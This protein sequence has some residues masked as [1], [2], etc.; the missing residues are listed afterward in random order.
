MTKGWVPQRTGLPSLNG[1]RKATAVHLE[2]GIL[3]W[4]HG[5]TVKCFC[6]HKMLDDTS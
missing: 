6:L 3:Q 5:T 2:V 4:L 1:I